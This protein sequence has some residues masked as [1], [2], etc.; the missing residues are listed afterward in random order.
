MVTSEDLLRID[1]ETGEQMILSIGAVPLDRPE[2][3]GGPLAV[4]VLHDVTRERTH[5]RELQAFAGTVA[6][7]L[8][9]PLTGVGSWA[10]ILGDQLDVLGVDVTEP[11]SSLRRIEASAARM[12]QLISDLLAYSQAQSADAE[13]R[14]RCR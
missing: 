3:E 12:D 9:A 5:R 10:E 8:K 11:R 2:A 13:P 6:H 14:R 4:L 7:D 1:P